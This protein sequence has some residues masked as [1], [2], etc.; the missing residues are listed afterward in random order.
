MTSGRNVA[1]FEYEAGGH[2]YTT[3]GVSQRGVGHAERIAWRELKDMNVEPSQ[4]TR[5]YSELEPCSAPGGYCK[6][7]IS[8]T[9]PDTS[10]T[11]SF[12]YGATK[13]SRKAGVDALRKAAEIAAE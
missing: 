10:V 11:Y 8:E 13:A 2:Y 6:R 7:F 12:E 1:V 5:I 4:V 9:F 3:T